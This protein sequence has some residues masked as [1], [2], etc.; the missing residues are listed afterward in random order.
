MKGGFRESTLD[1]TK[2]GIGALPI[3]RSAISERPLLSGAAVRG[4]LLDVRGWSDAVGAA[5]E[6][7]GL[8]LPYQSPKPARKETTS[9][10]RSRL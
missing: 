4:P 6:A 9:P 7:D 5:A 2:T 10:G 1:P 8:L 3:V